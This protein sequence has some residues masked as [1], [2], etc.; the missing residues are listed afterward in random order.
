MNKTIGTWT[1]TADTEFEHGTSSPLDSRVSKVPAG[2][3]NIEER[4]SRYGG[5]YLALV[6]PSCVERRC[7]VN[8]IGQRYT[9][10]REW[11]ENC[12]FI[13]QIGAWQLPEEPGGKH[14]LGE[15]ITISLDKY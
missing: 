1:I 8:R 11:V 7:S 5:T 15:E 12:E 6:A 14:F 13:Y 9:A 10:P 4:K 3:Y 2:T